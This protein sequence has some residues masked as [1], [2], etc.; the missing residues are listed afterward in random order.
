MRKWTKS[1]CVMPAWCILPILV[2]VGMQSPVRPAQ[3]IHHIASSTTQVTLTAFTAAATPAATPK[4]VV[5]PGDTLSGISAALALRGSSQALYAA[6]RHAIGPHPNVIRTGTVWT[7]PFLARQA[8]PASHARRPH[9]SASRAKPAGQARLAPAK[10]QRASVASASGRP[11]WLK[12]MLLVA[13]TIIGLS[14]LTE[15]IKPISRRHMRKRRRRLA[16]T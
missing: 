9:S 10:K 16:A 13:G 4:Y 12:T 2:A 6:N 8:R 7:A 14:L 5:Q 15:P 3:A 11:R 1:A